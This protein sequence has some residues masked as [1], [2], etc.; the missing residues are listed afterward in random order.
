[1]ALLGVLHSTFTVQIKMHAVIVDP[2]RVRLYV[3]SHVEGEDLTDG[4][5]KILTAYADYT[6][7]NYSINQNFTIKGNVLG[8]HQLI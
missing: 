1:M 7:A 4:V 8:V 5:V 2:H 6:A 3:K